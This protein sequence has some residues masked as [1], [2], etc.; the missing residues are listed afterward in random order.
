MRET[1]KGIPVCPGPDQN[2]IAPSFEVP[3]GAVDCHA[4]IFGPES[5]YPYSPARGYTPPDA[6]LASFHQ[7]HEVLGINRAVLIQPS[8]YGTDNSAMLDAVAQSQGNLLAVAAVGEEVTS[9]ELERLHQSKVRGVRINLVDKGGMP[10]SSID[11]VRRLTQRIEPYGWHLEVLIHVHQFPDL[12]EIVDSMAVDVVVGHLGYMKTS[13]SI[14]NPGFQDFLELLKLG[15]TWVK[16]CGSY[17]I[18]VEEQAPYADVIPF[19]QALI[20]TAPDR[21]IWGSDWPHPSFWGNMPNDGV[22]F[23]QLV[24]WAPTQEVRNKILVT[25]PNKLYGFG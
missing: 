8:V 19:A 21:I 17:R 9:E 20:T 2:P 5:K 15:K 7:L 24:N 6:S 4:H 14:A 22:L 12:A 25:N 1:I 23:D 10:F 11:S 3:I 18:S 16:L 13:E